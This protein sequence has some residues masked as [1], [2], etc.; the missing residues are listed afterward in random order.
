MLLLSVAFALITIGFV[1]PCLLDVARTP[2]HDFDLPAKTTWLLVIVA[3]WA[4]GATAWLLI[5]RRDLRARR[6]W[7]EVAG[8]QPPGQQWA[9]RRHPAG[10]APDGTG[11][12][13][14][15]AVAGRRSA[16]PAARFVAPDDNQ[17]FLVELDRRIREWREEA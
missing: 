9:L 14:T 12:Q 3:F 13:I 6:M 5:G 7:D 8:S 4:F 11:F 16:A 10:R 2:Q 17:D 1:A 15:D